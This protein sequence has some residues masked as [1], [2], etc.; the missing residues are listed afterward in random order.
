MYDH[1][2]KLLRGF[3]LLSGLRFGQFNDLSL[4]ERGAFS[5]M[6]EKTH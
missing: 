6:M 2:F 5:T 3:M 1:I 4:A